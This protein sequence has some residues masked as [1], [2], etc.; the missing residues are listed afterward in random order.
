MAAPK[1]YVS[2]VD[3]Q[4]QPH[5]PHNQNPLYQQQIRSQSN[6]P[7]YQAP[8]PPRSQIEAMPPFANTLLHPSANPQLSHPSFQNPAALQH[9]LQTRPAYDPAKCHPV[10]FTQSLRRPPF[11]F[12]DSGGSGAN[13]PVAFGYVAEQVGGGVKGTKL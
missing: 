12:T 10:F 6:Q 2:N 4:L 1:L 8:N 9:F 11:V 7:I 3:P 13:N 5:V